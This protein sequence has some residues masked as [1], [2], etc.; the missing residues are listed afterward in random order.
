M[1]SMLN[2]NTCLIFPDPTVPVSAAFPMLDASVT[3]D[4]TPA[5][6]S[7]FAFMKC[8][9]EEYG[10]RN[11]TAALLLR[12]IPANRD[13]RLLSGFCEGDY[14]RFC[15]IFHV[16]RL[17]V[18]DE[19][20]PLVDIRGYGHVEKSHHHFVRSLIAPRNGLGWIGIVGVVAGVVVP[21]DGAQTRTG[22]G[23]ARLGQA[24]TQLPVKVIVH[25]QQRLRS[26]ERRG[27]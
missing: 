17:P 2:S 26:G 27:G 19:V 9:H 25:F 10:P 18:P 21:G 22:L 4:A 20:M 13:G 24:I 23:R 3:A 12:E 5:N 11:I 16:G 1:P 15:L 6:T 14:S 8:L 7:F